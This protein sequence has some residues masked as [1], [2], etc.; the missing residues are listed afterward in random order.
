MSFPKMSFPRTGYP[1]SLLYLSIRVCKSSTFVRLLLK[2]KSYII[3]FTVLLGAKCCFPDSNWLVWLFSLVSVGLS[4]QRLFRL[5]SISES[6]PWYFHSFSVD[7]CCRETLYTFSFTKH[8]QHPW[9]YCEKLFRRFCYSI[10][11]SPR[12]IGCIAA[13]K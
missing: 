5:Q 1:F 4:R 6:G 2:S 10:L 3:N 8:F 13:P 12:E 9:I 7:Q 11:F